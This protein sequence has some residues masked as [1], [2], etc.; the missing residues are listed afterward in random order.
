MFISDILSAEGDE[1]ITGKPVG[2]DEK[3]KK[4]TYV[5]K[6]GLEKAKDIL[7]EITNDAVQIAESYGEKAEFLRRLA[8]F[9]KER[10]K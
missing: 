2:N 9:I 6:Y 1:K 8:I 10:N 7:N 4:C 3:R 5:S